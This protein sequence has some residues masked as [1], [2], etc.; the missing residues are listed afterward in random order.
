ML[1]LSTDARNRSRTFGVENFSK[2]AADG[3]SQSPSRFAPG[4][5]INQQPFGFYLHGQLDGRCFATIERASYVRCE[6]ELWF[7][8]A[9]PP[10]VD[11]AFDAFFRRRMTQCREFSL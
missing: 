5:L 7:F 9:K 11:R 1:H 4:L 8:Y 6:W 3:D 10:I 2:H